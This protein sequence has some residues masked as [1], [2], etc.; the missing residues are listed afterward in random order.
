MPRRFATVRF[1]AGNSGSF[2]YFARADTRG[3]NTHLLPHSRHNRAQALQVRIPPAT[4]RV[5]CVADHISIVRRFAAEFTLQCHISSCFSFYL[6]LDLLLEM[7]P[8]QAPHSSRP[9]YLRQSAPF[10]HRMVLRGTPFVFRMVSRTRCSPAHDSAG[11][12]A[13]SQGSKPATCPPVLP[14]GIRSPVAYQ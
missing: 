9:H 13:S 3:A 11:Q 5:I 6:G 2:L 8:N 7:S 10:A 12:S 1:K 14:Y 4:P